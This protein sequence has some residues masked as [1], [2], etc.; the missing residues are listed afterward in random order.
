MFKLFISEYLKSEGAFIVNLSMNYGA[1]H[2]LRKSEI[3]AEI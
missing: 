1:F 2:L 3:G